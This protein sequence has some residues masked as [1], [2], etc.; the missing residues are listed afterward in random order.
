[1]LQKVTS[2]NA[3]SAAAMI[4]FLA[5]CFISSSKMMCVA[6]TPRSRRKMR[7]IRAKRPHRATSIAG[8]ENGTGGKGGDT[9]T[10]NALANPINGGNGGDRITGGGG[11]D[12]L[13]GGNGNDTFV[14]APGFGNDTIN[15]FDANPTG[16]QDI[17]DVSALGIT[18]ADFAL[19][20]LIEDLGTDTLVTVDNNPNQNILLVGVN[21]NGANV[22]TMADFFLHT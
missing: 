20:V 4:A 13:N 16:G 10:G 1:M 22:I 14:F 8:I 18:E 11:N 19:R 6:R 2:I 5:R 7:K 21:G 12:A 9:L 15:G 17:L 3:I